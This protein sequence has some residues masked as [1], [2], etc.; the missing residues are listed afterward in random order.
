MLAGL[1]K[2]VK[3]TTGIN[4]DVGRFRSDI[5]GQEL[6]AGTG[7]L[8]AIGKGFL[9]EE[10]YQKEKLGKALLAKQ[11]QDEAAAAQLSADLERKKLAN[12]YEE[13]TKSTLNP[14]MVDASNAFVRFAINF[15]EEI[16]RMNRALSGDR[17]VAFLQ[18][19][20]GRDLTASELFGA[21][22][23]QS[24]TVSDRDARA[25]LYLDSLRK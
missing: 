6:D 3:F 18:A 24:T 14:A 2:L 11:A 20:K 16:E 4:V 12:L 9:T 5:I 8:E 21:T 1:E 19:R 22:R 10:Q 7:L 17:G 25:F 13:H 15:K 23:L